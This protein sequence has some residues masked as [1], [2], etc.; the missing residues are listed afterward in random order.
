MQ[1]RK[2]YNISTQNRTFWRTCLKQNK[3]TLRTDVFYT[4][5]TLNTLNK[6]DTIIRF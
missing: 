5:N 3:H 1:K 6:L 2:L 4:L